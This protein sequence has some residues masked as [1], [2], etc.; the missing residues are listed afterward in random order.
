M[1]KYHYNVIGK[2]VPR[3][4]MSNFL[5]FFVH[6]KVSFV[7]SN[8]ANGNHKVWLAAPPTDSFFLSIFSLCFRHSVVPPNSY[9]SLKTLIEFKLIIS[10]ELKPSGVL[11]QENLESSQVNLPQIKTTLK[12]KKKLD[13]EVALMLVCD[14]NDFQ[15]L[16][17]RT[18]DSLEI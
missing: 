9:N 3:N 13:V 11:F 18:C 1:Y 7:Q 12:K 15:R 10:H 6:S 8:F 2:H 14:Q 5:L 4:Q 17:D 16:F